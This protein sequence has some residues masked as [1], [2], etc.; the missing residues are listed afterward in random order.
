MNMDT[1]GD[2]LILGTKGGLRIPSTECW[3][4]SVGGPM[5]IYHEVAGNQVET[6]IPIT[7]SD[8]NGN[9]ER[10]IRSFLDALKYNLPSPVP[11]EQIIYNQAIIDGLVK[12]SKLGK[13]VEIVIP[14]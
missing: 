6:V 11:S 8:G 12:S 4:G 10:K 1:A 2:T 9:F 5:T 14:E 7:E 3:N 13:E